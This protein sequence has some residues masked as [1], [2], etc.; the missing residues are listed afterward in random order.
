VWIFR[1]RSSSVH[2]CG[3]TRIP[4]RAARVQYPTIWFAVEHET[5]EGWSVAT[6]IETTSTARAV[7][8]VAKEEG[9]YRVSTGKATKAEYFWVPAGGTPQP[10]RRT[11]GRSHS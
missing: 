10:L 3:F 7:A 5:E 9:V 6:E 11:S 8:H 1:L 2:H 4:A